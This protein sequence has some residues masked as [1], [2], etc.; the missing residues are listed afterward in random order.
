MSDGRVMAA[1]PSD[2][3]IQW[4]GHPEEGGT[5]DMDSARTSL[6][7]LLCNGECGVREQVAAYFEEAQSF[8]KEHIR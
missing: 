5:P 2:E 6:L 8:L 1:L 3:P 4:N 7:C